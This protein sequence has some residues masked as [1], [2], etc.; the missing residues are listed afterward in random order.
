MPTI[1]PR[2]TIREGG[3]VYEP[4]QSYEVAPEIEFYFKK[5]GWV[6]D[7]EQSSAGPVTLEIN[8]GTHGHTAPE[9]KNG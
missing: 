1:T 4:G 8:D 5:M 9:V 2:H 3:E 6:E 7:G